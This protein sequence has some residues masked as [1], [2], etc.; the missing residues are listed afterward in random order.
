MLLFLDDKIDA[1]RFHVWL[2]VGLSAKGNLLLVLHAL[3][4][5]DLEDLPLPLSFE[6][7][8]LALALG[9]PALDLLDH[10]QCDLAELDDN[11]LSVAI[12]TDLGGSNNDLPGDCELDG[13]SVVQILQGDLEGMVDVFSAAGTRASSA[14][15]TKE[16]AKEVVLASAAA[17]ALFQSLEAE[18]VVFGACFR[19]AQNFVS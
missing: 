3:L 2:F 10:S 5:Q 17:A 7:V 18:F 4:D 8:A 14:T 1:P 6:L 19:I 16:H 11:P 15:A 12:V 9:T 13:L